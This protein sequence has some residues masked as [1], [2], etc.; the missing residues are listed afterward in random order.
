M[1]LVNQ[2]TEKRIKTIWDNYVADK[3][4]LDKNGNEIV[5]I[6]SSRLETIKTLK[7]IIDD[8]LN[9][10]YNVYEFKTAVDSLNKRNNYWGFTATKGQMYFNQLVRN[11]E[12]H[13]DK[14]TLLLKECLKQPKSLSEAKNKISKLEEYSASIFYKAADKRKAPNPASV[15]YFLSY[16]WQI[17]DW[18]SWPIIYTSLINAFE[19]LAIWEHKKQQ[20]DAY[21]YF[22][23]LYE[24]I[25]L[26]LSKHSGQSVSNW[27]AEHAFWNFNG[28]P[29]KVT[30]AKK[31]SELAKDDFDKKKEK[32]DSR[33]ALTAS[34]ELSDYLIPKVARLTDLG[35][36]VSM[37]S[38]SKGAEYER[39]VAEI[40]K[41]LDF[42]VELL[43]Q[44]KGRNPDAIIKVREDNTAFIVDAKAYS[45]GYNMG[46]DDRAIREYINYY[47]PKLAK[48]GYRKIGFI[49][50]SNSF[51]SD[52][53]SFINEITWNTEI[54]RFVLLTSDALLYF[55]AYKTKDRLSVST[56]IESL[57]S[58]SSP[59][60]STSVIQEFDDI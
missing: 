58:L 32:E 34:F 42:E 3:K 56:I 57:I 20:D 45:S 51:K 54:K 49:I 33:P 26:V 31:K 60:L 19:T 5:E 1:I 23:N 4:V 47:C 6:D 17:Q 30:P 13:I 59:I 50:V 28:N 16:F 8:F 43:G 38:S 2:E 25:K 18:Q 15:G 40:F 24:E 53:S 14:F 10:R 27:Q 11:S 55:L 48:D 35:N 44:G 37:S 22:Y 39:L 41:Q 36:E 46:L 7:E 12:A 9:G 21:E 29:N 52:L